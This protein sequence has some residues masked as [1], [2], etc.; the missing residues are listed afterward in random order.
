MNRSIAKFA[1][2][3]A[4]FSPASGCESLPESS[5][6]VCTQVG[7]FAP[8][9]DVSKHVSQAVDTTLQTFGTHFAADDTS[10]VTGKFRL[11][12]SAG[13]YSVGTLTMVRRGDVVAECHG[14]IPGT[15]ECQGGNIPSGSQPNSLTDTVITNYQR[16]SVAPTQLFHEQYVT[17]STGST[18]K[19]A[20]PSDAYPYASMRLEPNHCEAT[21]HGQ[22]GLSCGDGQEVCVSTF[23]SLQ[24][25]V[26]QLHQQFTKRVGQ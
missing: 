3:A 4:V 16:V 20:L 9:R 17:G 2:T 7:N 24:D 19:K 21:F 8:L 1:F 15:I 12:A 10:L 5:S 11:D 26:K 23:A 25:R 18:A 6:Q 22:Q 14:E 13:D